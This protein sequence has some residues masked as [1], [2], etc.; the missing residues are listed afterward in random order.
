MI[1]IF[2]PLTL[3]LIY[4]LYTK[5]SGLYKKVITVIGAVID[6]VVNMTWFSLIFLD[7]PQEWLLTQRVERLKDSK[8]YRQKLALLI[9]QLLNHFEAGHCD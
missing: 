4:I 1:Y 6:F 9:C 3:L 8:G 5:S 2:N 7:I